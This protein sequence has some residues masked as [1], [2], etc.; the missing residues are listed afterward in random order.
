MIPAYYLTTGPDGHSHV[1]RGSIADNQVTAAQSVMFKET[2]PHA[3]L[4]WHNAPTT[5]Y[6]ITLSGTLEFTMHDGE[7]F[8]LR[9]GDI[10]IALDT[11]GTGHSWRLIDDQ[12]WRR[13]YVVFGL[14]AKINF[15]PD[16][17]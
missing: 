10:L 6:V 9:P 12:P 4:E 7:T 14:D 8:T 11:T 1:T 5:Q 16:P 3:T 2:P 13:L 15:V 17:L